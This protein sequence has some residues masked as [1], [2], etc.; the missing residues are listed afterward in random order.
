MRTAFLIIFVLLQVPVF[1]QS[2]GKNEIPFE[3]LPS[4]HLLVKTR[5]DGVTGSFIFDTGAG[6]TLFTKD[7]FHKLTH[8]AKEDG[9]YTGFRATGERMD[10]QLFKVREFEFGSFKKAVEEV[11]WLDVNLGGIDGIISLKLL[12]T[13]PFTIDFKRKVIVLETQQSLT[14]IRKTATSL[15]VQSEQSRNKSLTLFSYFKINDTLTLQLSLDSGAGKDIYRLNSRYMTALG[16]NEKDTAQVKKIEKHSEFN[17]QHVSAIYTTRLPKIA[18]A[19]SAA[20]QVTAIPVQFVEGLIYD[21]IMWINW[22]GSRISFDLDH[23]VLL[24]QR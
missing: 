10:I 24:V 21:G 13:Q 8:T 16:V 20:I 11:S 18:A 3:L 12:E 7:F 22:L 9:G 23:Q 17:N 6:I 2:I 19:N 5:V 4:G 14:T 1:S 15:P